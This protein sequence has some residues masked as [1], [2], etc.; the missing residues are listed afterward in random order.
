MQPVYE[1]YLFNLSATLL[2]SVMITKGFVYK[3]TILKF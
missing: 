3:V 1:R 2:R